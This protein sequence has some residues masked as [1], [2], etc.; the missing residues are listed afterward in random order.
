[1][2]PLFQVDTY[3]HV[4]ITTGICVC[5]PSQGCKNLKEHR[6]RKVPL[7]P[8]SNSESLRQVE[9]DTCLDPAPLTNILFL[10]TKEPGSREAKTCL[11]PHSA[12][13]VGPGP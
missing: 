1:M 8:R 11:W 5:I 9:R 13:Q 10:Q 6:C 2:K 7:C 4:F 3:V 12:D